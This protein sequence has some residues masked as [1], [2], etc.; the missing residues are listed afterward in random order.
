MPA[1]FEELGAVHELDLWNINVHSYH[2][3]IQ[4][5][6]ITSLGQLGKDYVIDN[7]TWQV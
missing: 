5:F 3:H 6:E 4:P 2:H 7:G 1:M